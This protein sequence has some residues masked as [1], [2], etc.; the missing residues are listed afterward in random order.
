MRKIFIGSMVAVLTL[1]SCVSLDTKIQDNAPKICSIIEKGH[2]QFVV[3]A[4]AGLVSQKT[5]DKEANAYAIAAPYCVDP[6]KLTAEDVLLL[7]V[8]QLVILKAAKESQDG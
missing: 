6:S 8:Q 5:I 2:A 4:A 7:T 3:V 1:S